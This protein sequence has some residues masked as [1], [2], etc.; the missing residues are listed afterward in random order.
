ML[1]T[2]ATPGLPPS[3]PPGPTQCVGHTCSR[4]LPR[5]PQACSLSSS[6][7]RPFGWWWAPFSYNHVPANLNQPPSPP[8]RSPP[9]ALS[10]SRAQTP[11][12]PKGHLGKLH[13]GEGCPGTSRDTRGSHSLKCW[14]PRHHRSLETFPS[15]PG[16]VR[17]PGWGP[18]E[19]RG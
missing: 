12:L 6:P 4:G 14:S 1:V 9:S 13:G 18:H 19:N 11:H 8:P 17:C 3:F 2:R 15:A 5:Q 16:G 10:L 7:P